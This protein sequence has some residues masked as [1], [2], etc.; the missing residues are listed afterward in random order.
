MLGLNALLKDDREV[1]DTWTPI[2]QFEKH[3]RTVTFTGS[4]NTSSGQP[5]EICGKERL[6]RFDDIAHDVTTFTIT[7]E[8]LQRT[9]G[10]RQGLRK[11][12]DPGQP[13][14]MEDFFNCMRSRGPPKCHVDEAFIETA[15][16]PCP[17]SPTSARQVRWDPVR[18]DIV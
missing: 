9:Q 11:R 10:L 4:M 16:S 17:S 18:E 2:Y 12:Q 13:N 6:L 15:T 8:R 7:P 1:P 5:V 14:H 3:G